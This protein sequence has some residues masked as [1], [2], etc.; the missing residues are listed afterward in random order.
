MHAAIQ[1]WH[2]GK[3]EI[4]GTMKDLLAPLGVECIDAHAVRKQHP[5]RILNGWELK[6]YAIKYSSFR[7]ILYLDADNVP[8]VNPEFLFETQEFLESGAIFWP[9]YGRLSPG[10]PIWEV[11]DVLYR[12]EPEFESGQIVLDKTRCWAPL[13]LALWYNE[14]SDFYYKYVLG[15]L[16]LELLTS[17]SRMWSMRGEVSSLPRNS[18][19]GRST[20]SR[21]NSSHALIAGPRLPTWR[22]NSPPLEIP[23]MRKMPKDWLWWPGSSTPSRPTRLKA[24]TASC[25]KQWVT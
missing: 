25:S 22:I 16:H 15:E 18:S 21:R 2:L 8:V 10:N 12:N 5:A 4:D 9:D 20:N 3:Q 14:N 6:P 1:L 13:S 19:A 23:G 17:S 7:E 11:G 24:R